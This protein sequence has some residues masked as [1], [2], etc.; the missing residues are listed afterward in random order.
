VGIGAGFAVDFSRYL[1]EN[2]A[3]PRIVHVHAAVFTVWMLLLT[4]QVLLVL[5]NRVAWNRRLGWFAA[6]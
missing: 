5:G 6:G 4:A 2:P 3:P 1:Q